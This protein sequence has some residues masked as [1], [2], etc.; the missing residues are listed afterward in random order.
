MRTTNRRVWVG[1]VLVASIVVFLAVRRSSGAGPSYAWSVQLPTQGDSSANV[2][3]P[4]AYVFRHGIDGAFARVD[5]VRG[6][7]MYSVLR[8]ELLASTTGWIGF[9]D[10][11]AASN[12]LDAGHSQ[13][14]HF[15]AN[16]NAEGWPM[17]D[18]HFGPTLPVD[19]LNNPN[20]GTSCV[21][22]FLSGSGPFGHKHPT[23]PYGVVILELVAH[24]V[25]LDGVPPGSTVAAQPGNLKIAVYR[26]SSCGPFTE[27]EPGYSGIGLTAARAPWADIRV[28]RDSA[29]DTWVVEV[30]MPVGLYEYLAGTLVPVTKGPLKGPLSC[31]AGPL[32]QLTWTDP[33]RTV[34]T[35]RR[36]PLP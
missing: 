35:W 6:R 20:D 9:R 31:A 12:R 30:L 14:C 11:T 27:L 23:F 32:A 15:P 22:D 8:L 4:D 13:V 33:V 2:F 17:L 1:I 16:F 25:D 21:V 26:Q 28:T 10:I 34:M 24:G 5:V 29:G 36:T 3:G 19:I 7:S 18:G